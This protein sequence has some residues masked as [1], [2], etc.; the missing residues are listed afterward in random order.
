MKDIFKDLLD[1]ILQKHDEYM[2][3]PQLLYARLQ[4]DC[5]FVQDEV[6]LISQSKT[7]TEKLIVKYYANWGVLRRLHSIILNFV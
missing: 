5:Y 7:T 6:D 1:E 3:D 4:A 2:I